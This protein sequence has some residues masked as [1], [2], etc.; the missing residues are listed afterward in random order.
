[1]ESECPREEGEVR[2]EQTKTGTS[3]TYGEAVHEKERERRDLR[4]VRRERQEKQRGVK[5]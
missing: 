2:E 5:I 4:R 3:T 1:M